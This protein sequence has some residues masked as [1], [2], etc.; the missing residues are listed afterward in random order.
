MNIVRSTLVL[1]LLALL[2]LPQHLTA[3]MSGQVVNFC[4]NR[5]NS[6]SNGDKLPVEDGEI[7][8]TMHMRGWTPA[9]EYQTSTAIRTTV[10]GDPAP[11]FL[12]ARMDFHNAPGSL[13]DVRRMT[14][15]STGEVGIGF[16]QGHDPVTLFDVNGDARVRGMRVYLEDPNAPGGGEA[17]T[18]IGA[19]CLGVPLPA[20]NGLGLNWGGGFADGVFVDGPGL[21]VCGVM[22][23]N[24]LTAEEN[25]S[26]R[27]GNIYTLGGEPVADPCA[28]PAEGDFIAHGPNSDFIARRGHFIADEGDFTATEGSMTAR[29]DITS[30]TGD[31]TAAGGTVRADGNVESDNGDVVASTGNVTAGMNVTAVAGDVSA[32]VG[33]VTAG[34]DVSALFDV[35]AGQDMVAGR[36]I[37]SN[38]DLF[39]ADNLGIGLATDDVTMGWPDGYRLA[40]AGN[41]IC[42]EVRVALQGDWPDYVFRPG[43]ELMPLAELERY[44]RANGHLPRVPA[45]QEMEAGGMELGE[46]QRIMVEKIEELTLYTIQQQEELEELRRQNEEL[47][48]MV[49][50][51]VGK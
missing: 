18:R 16:P 33:N 20:S 25:I 51:L 27:T 2:S 38:D 23:S 46:M 47:R 29:L 34:M 45:A 41:V 40:V 32:A 19:D 9:G 43:Y 13:Y 22:E 37:V 30:E 44:V 24:C 42:E 10:T 12:P 1:A 8:A 35:T 39:V 14:I 7:I 49:E 11:G 5:Y 3:Q 48:G 4:L 6:A 15:L 50:K 36:D 21:S 31:I 28:L 17:L 26:S